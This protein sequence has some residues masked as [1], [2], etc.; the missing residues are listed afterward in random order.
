MSDFDELVEA[1]N[2]ENDIE[3]EP[4]NYRILSPEEREYAWARL[5][6]KSSIISA[7]KESYN[8]SNKEEI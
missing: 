8:K 4:L 3:D 7:F 5:I 1:V 6:F 2:R